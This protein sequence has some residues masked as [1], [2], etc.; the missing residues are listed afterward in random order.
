MEG[1]AKL[2]IESTAAP[3]AAVDKSGARVREMFGQIAPRY[4]RLNHLLSLQIDRYW[5][6]YT[7]GRLNL[8]DG[9]PIL[10]VCTGT[11]DLALAID[12]RMQGRAPV[13]GADFCREMLV[14]AE[15]KAQREHR[16]VRFLE[17][18]AQALPFADET[19]Q[20]VTVAF[21]LRN[22]A[23]T[24]RGLAELV[25]VCRPGGQ[26]VVLEFS[27]PDWPGLKQL[28]QWY[29]RHILPRV[30]QRLARN[31]RSAYH[32]LPASVREFPSGAGLC[33]RL[34]ASGLE[35]VQHQPLTGGIAT[36]YEGRR[37]L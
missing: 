36:Y 6:R 5:R 20:A 1:T 27:Q 21:G 16:G 12:R 24:A 22:V 28:Y 2:M 17:A 30:G 35:R 11:G 10:D 13:V 14:L 19:F 23:D 4:D 25:R 26:V 29:F 3:P 15:G 34:S 7:V 9:L 18:D 31:D 37:P 32:Y 8:A 33:E